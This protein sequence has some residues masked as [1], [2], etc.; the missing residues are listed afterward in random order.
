MK[1][2]VYESVIALGGASEDN[3]CQIN[4]RL[5]IELTPNSSWVDDHPGLPGPIS[6]ACEARRAAVGDGRRGRPRGGPAGSAAARGRRRGDGRGARGARPAL[7][8]GRVGAG[9]G[10]GCIDKTSVWRW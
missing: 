6:S 1:N 2:V 5:E 7:G 10:M 9:E 8:G 4:L 3:R